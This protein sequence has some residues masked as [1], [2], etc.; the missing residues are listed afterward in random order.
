M[1]AAVYSE[2]GPPEVLEV[3]E[4]G[5]PTPKDSEV[6]VKIKAAAVTSA[7]WRLRKADPFMVRFFAG[8]L[9]PKNTILGTGLAGE[10]EATGDGVKL[11]KCGDPVFGSA[12]FGSGAYAEYISLPQ[13]GL[14]AEKPGNLT[15]EESAAVFFGGHAALHFLRKGGIGNGQKVLIYGA[16]GS[17]GTFAVQLAKH[18]GAKVTGVCST[19]NLEMV[20][21]LGADQVIDYTR[22]DF[23]RRSETYDIIF[24]T[25]GK[26][27]FSGSVRA[28]KPKGY[29][30]RTVH[31]SPGAVLR[32][33]WV[34]LTSGKRVIGGV[35]QEKKEDLLLLKKLAEEGRI[36]PVI[37]RVYPLEQIVQAHEYVEKG[38]KKGNVVVSIAD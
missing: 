29:Y 11:F 35:A 3:K 27:P 36:R 32:G 21:S 25:V 34:N 10:I 1:K 5:K 24:D 31:T 23:S 26:S 20:K 22:E 38:H 30:L 15:F 7:D 33:L 8:L 6:L 37:D 17:V 2:Y 9:K 28:L 19:A 16:S 13:D 14:L 4:A 12:G 18:F